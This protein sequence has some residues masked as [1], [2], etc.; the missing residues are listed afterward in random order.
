L[1]VPSQSELKN[2]YE[3]YYNF[4]GENDTAY[5]RIREYFFL[6][7]LYRFWL[8]IDGD[9]CFH[10]KRGRGRLLDVGCNEGRGLRIY[11]NN[12]FE[13]EGLEL[14]ER[15]AAEAQ[16]RGFRVHTELLEDFRPEKPYDVVVL[17]NVLEH[18]LQ[19]Q[20]MLM[21]VSRIL[22]PGGQ[23]WISCPNIESW[24]RSFLGNYW[25]NWHVPFHIVHFSPATLRDMLESEGFRVVRTRQATP[26]S[27]MAQTLIA[28]LFSR[29]RRA[30]RE[31]RN[32]FLVA[33]LMLFARVFLFP[34]LW[35]GNRLGRGDCLIIVAKKA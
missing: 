4:G 33:P 18:S 14:N 32:P 19:P 17:S 24:Q 1:P 2:L 10:L 6:S 22:R 11:K 27:W 12:G 21:H 13:V 16:K 29:P 35:L 9:I 28:R 30:T 25:I 34:L 15:A 26:A 3:T 23:V 8:S 7:P 20:E 5:P 31:L